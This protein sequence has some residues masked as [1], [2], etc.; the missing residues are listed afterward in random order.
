MVFGLLEDKLDEVEAH[1]K[2]QGGSLC[3][4]HVDVSNPDQ[5][6]AGFDWLI[7]RYNRLDYLFNNAGTTLLAELDEASLEQLHRLIDVNLKGVVTGIRHAYP[8]MKAAQRGH[9]INTASLAGV[10][11]YPTSSVYAATKAA[12]I[13][14]TDDLF[15]RRARRECTSLLPFQAT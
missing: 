14:L 15:S 13:R 5:M 6:Q 12:V 8:L 10:T 9:I 2:Q 4:R 7:G 3:Y 11:G 1:I